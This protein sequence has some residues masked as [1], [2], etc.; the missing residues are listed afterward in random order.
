MLQAPTHSLDLRE[1][2]SL[3]RGFSSEAEGM[4]AL[5]NQKRFDEGPALPGSLGRTALAEPHH[6]GAR[7]REGEHGFGRHIVELGCHPRERMNP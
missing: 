7:L 1:M 4:Q 2:V 5:V 3:V 6:P